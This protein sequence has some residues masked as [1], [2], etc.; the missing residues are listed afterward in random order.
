MDFCLSKWGF[1]ISI[2]HP[3]SYGKRNSDIGFFLS[4]GLRN[5]LPKVSLCSACRQSLF[6]NRLRQ[7]F[8][9]DF[10]K[11][12]RNIKFWSFLLALFVSI[13]NLQERGAGVPPLL[14]ILPKH[15]G[16]LLWYYFYSRC[17]FFG[18]NNS[19]KLA[20]HFYI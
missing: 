17:N 10:K 13:T 15:N 3:V 8:C 19:H 12:I 20:G 5:N 14:N 2:A 11:N 7:A 6:R 9:F 16:R 1:I 18:K 4:L